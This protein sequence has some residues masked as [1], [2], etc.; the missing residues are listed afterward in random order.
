M[1]PLGAKRGGQARVQIKMAGPGA[2]AF[3]LESVGG[4][5]EGM[6]E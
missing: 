1:M 3:M 2:H 6:L 5:L 4:M